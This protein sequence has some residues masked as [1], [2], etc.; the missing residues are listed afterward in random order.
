MKKTGCRAQGS[1]GN[2]WPFTGNQAGMWLLD[3]RRLEKHKG[4]STSC[5][6]GGGRGHGHCQSHSSGDRHCLVSPV[7]APVGSLEDLH[8]A[9]RRMEG[10]KQG[11]QGCIKQDAVLPCAMPPWLRTSQA[12]G[13][14]WT[15]IASHGRRGPAWF[16]LV[17]VASCFPPVDTS[18]PLRSLE[19][20][21]LGDKPLSLALLPTQAPPETASHLWSVWLEE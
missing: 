7:P 19:E 12:T 8:W 6:A 11:F 9:Q 14:P 5:R 13:E 3:S 15:P 2:W 1:A 16:Q 20:G 10:R 17:P 4:L 21:S 18:L